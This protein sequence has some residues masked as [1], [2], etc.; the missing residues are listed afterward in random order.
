MQHFSNH[1]SMRSISEDA[2]SREN[3]NSFDFFKADIDQ[4]QPQPQSQPKAQSQAQSHPFGKELE[5]LD[6]AVEE[7]DGA[8]QAIRSVERDNDL[9]IMEQQGLRKFCAEDYLREIRPLFSRIF[10]PPAVDWI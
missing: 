3:R 4:P 2:V 1:S 8:F 7:F 5:Q 6:E 9:V 10:S